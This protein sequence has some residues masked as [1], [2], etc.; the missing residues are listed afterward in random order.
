M[1]VWSDPAR[2]LLWY[3]SIAILIDMIVCVHSIWTPNTEKTPCGRTRTQT[4]KQTQKK[5][6]STLLYSITAL[7]AARSTQH[8]AHSTQHALQKIPSTISVRVG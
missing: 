1:C 3:K 7:H 5:R 8:A 6:L 2:S 4:H